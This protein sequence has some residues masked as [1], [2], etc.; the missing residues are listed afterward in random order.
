MTSRY[1]EGSGGIVRRRR[2]RVV[3]VINIKEMKS[4]VQVRER[5]ALKC[6][7]KIDEGLTS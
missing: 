3:G 7:F 5:P 6:C 4:C 2:L 1:V